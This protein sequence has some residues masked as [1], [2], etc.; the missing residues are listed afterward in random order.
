MQERLAIVER[1][2]AALENTKVEAE[3]VTQ[4][5]D[6]FSEVWDA[7]TIENRSHLVHAIVDRV[8]VNEPEGRV[9]AYLAKFEDLPDVPPDNDDAANTKPIAPSNL[10]LVHSEETP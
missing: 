10:K 5:L 8:V 6:A 3:W 7:L 2:L 9:D 4:T 1:D